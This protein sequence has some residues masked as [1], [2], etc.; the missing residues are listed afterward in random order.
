MDGS[1]LM[2]AAWTLEKL[3]RLIS[4]S[5]REQKEVLETDGKTE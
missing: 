1:R 3:Q 5:S 4:L 2:A